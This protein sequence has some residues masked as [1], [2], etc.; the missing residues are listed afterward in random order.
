MLY[1]FVL[2]GGNPCLPR[3]QAQIRMP[4][5]GVGHTDIALQLAGQPMAVVGPL[6]AGGKGRRRGTPRR[7]DFVASY[8][9]RRNATRG[10]GEVIA[11]G[12]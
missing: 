9:E 4:W 5:T 11:G 3:R 6:P 10:G 2:R 8:V 7:Y 1:P 12:R